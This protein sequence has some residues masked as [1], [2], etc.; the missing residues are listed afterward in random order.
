MALIR[1]YQCSIIVLLLSQACFH[2][3][4]AR[5]LRDRADIAVT[6]E[7]GAPTLPKGLSDVLNLSDPIW[8]EV[9]PVRPGRRDRYLHEFQESLKDIACF[10]KTVSTG[11]CKD[12]VNPDN[13]KGF[14]NQPW[15]PQFY[16][17][18]KHTCCKMDWDASWNLVGKMGWEVQREGNERD[19]SKCMKDTFQARQPFDSRPGCC[20]V[21]NGSTNF[22]VPINQATELTS[23]FLEDPKTSRSELGFMK[24]SPVFSLEDIADTEIQDFDGKPVTKQDIEK[25]LKHY[26]DLFT[27]KDPFILESLKSQSSHVFACTGSFDDMSECKHLRSHAPAQCCCNKASATPSQV[28]LKAPK[29]EGSQSK[30]EEKKIQELEYSEHNFG[31]YPS[32]SLSEKHHPEEEDEFEDKVQG[33]PDPN[34]GAEDLLEWVKAEGK[35]W[36]S[37]AVC[38][39][40]RMVPRVKQTVIQP[41]YT[42][43]VRTGRYYG[44]GQDEI[45]ETVQHAAKMSYQKADPEEMCDQWEWTRECPSDEALYDKVIKPGECMS[46]DQQQQNHLVSKDPFMYECPVGHV[47]PSTHA[48]CRCAVTC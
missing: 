33:M 6:D 15:G 31:G 44:E 34:G 21:A 24:T 43:Q 9:D 23:I 35:Q 30:V 4:S 45:M 32:G 7:E 29:K 28:C 27:V 46:A 1:S 20:A 48:D 26:E 36:K 14:G 47:D 2:V 12:N 16:D 38:K 40:K 10:C 18:E 5:P 37:D 13:P 19:F 42:E 22:N 11:T 41:A 17:R 25:M 3:W 39:H 8:T